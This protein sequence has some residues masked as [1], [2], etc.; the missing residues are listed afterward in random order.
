MYIIVVKLKEPYFFD[1]YY[2]QIYAV[3]FKKNWTWQIYYRK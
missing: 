3:N 1:K 2:V